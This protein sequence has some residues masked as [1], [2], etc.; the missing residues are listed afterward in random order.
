MTT[1]HE[2]T[3]EERH[4]L[5]PAFCS[6][7]LWQ[8]GKGA[9]ENT[10]SPRALSFNE[11]FLI[12]PLVLHQKTRNSLPSRT[13]SSLPVWIHDNPLVVESLPRR[14]SSLV[15]YTKAAII[16]G[17]TGE[18]FSFDRDE[19]LIILERNSDIQAMVRQ[20]S[21]EVQLC[22]KKAQFIGKWFTHTGNPETIF[23]LLG[24]RP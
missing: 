20:T 19:M 17:R 15:P 4:L 3:H 23:T 6:V 7:L 12:L 13:N 14:A 21:N 24:I 1:W 10:N 22:M 11:V 9:S 8:A 16:F 2:C 5:N 18:L